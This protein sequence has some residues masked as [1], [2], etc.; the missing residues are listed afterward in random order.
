MLA[1]LLLAGCT[2]DINGVPTTVAASPTRGSA[3]TLASP[4]AQAVATPGP[5]PLPTAHPTP[6]PVIQVTRPLTPV[7]HTA[8]PTTPGPSQAVRPATPTPSAA[9]PYQ[10]LP[11]LTLQPVETTAG[12]F[13]QP[14]TVRLRTAAEAQAFFARALGQPPL[15]VPPT[16]FTT[17][18]LLAFYDPG[19]DDAV[20]GCNPPYLAH[21]YEYSTQIAYMPALPQFV[22]DC[23]PEPRAPNY[24]F[25]SIA[26]REK[27]IV[28]IPEYVL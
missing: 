18:E 4:P 9:L 28:G 1:L 25:V 13:Y 12:L 8:P 5:V 16:D 27:P 26:R 2:E 11:F 17:H 24:Q 20:A 21:L 7:P 10:E 23:E 14:A 3:S 6:T 19:S 22:G 15:L